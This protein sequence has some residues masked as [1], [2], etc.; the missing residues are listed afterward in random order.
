MARFMSKREV[1]DLIGLHPESV[2][3]LAREGEFPKPIKPGNRANSRVRWDAQDI[4]RWI[5]DRK[6]ALVNEAV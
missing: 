4:E 1:S 5:A 3:R 6:A 2:M